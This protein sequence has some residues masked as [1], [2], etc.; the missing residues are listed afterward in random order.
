[1]TDASE[2]Q[3]QTE[4]REP[5]FRGW[6]QPVSRPPAA[7]AGGSRDD[8][9]GARAYVGRWHAEAAARRASHGSTHTE[10]SG[11]DVGPLAGSPAADAP[12]D[13]AR[14]PTPASG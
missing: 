14:L 2:A 7:D 6:F 4:A 12:A 3:D 11:A 10:T 13:T 1:M 8:A 9:N 5:G